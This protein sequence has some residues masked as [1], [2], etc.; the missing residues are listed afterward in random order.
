MPIIRS[1]MRNSA[2]I[3][4]FIQIIKKIQHKRK[5]II[6]NNRI[7]ISIVQGDLI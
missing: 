5:T 7:V 3:R 4:P 6:F 2:K 1:F